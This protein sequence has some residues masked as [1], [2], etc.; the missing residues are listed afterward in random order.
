MSNNDVAIARL[1]EQMRASHNL[2]KKIYEQVQKTNGRVTRLEKWR[3]Y[4][5]GFVAGLSCLFAIPEIL[6]V[7]EALLKNNF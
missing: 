4:A 2:T 7:L 6:K 1:E 3:N 5:L